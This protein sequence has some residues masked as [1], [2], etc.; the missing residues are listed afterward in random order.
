[1]PAGNKGRVPGVPDA[2]SASE[3]ETGPSLTLLLCPRWTRED[4]AESGGLYVGAKCQ[5]QKRRPRLKGGRGP[6]ALDAWAG[7]GCSRS[8]RV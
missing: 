1:M 4:Q 2:A 6:F 7:G 5:G 3:R 8:V